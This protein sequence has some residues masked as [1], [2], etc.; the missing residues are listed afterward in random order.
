MKFKQWL[1]ARDSGTKWHDMKIVY[2]WDIESNWNKVLRRQKM[3]LWVSPNKDI[4][5][6]WATWMVSGNERDEGG[7]GKN[8]FYLHK[9]GMPRDLF[10]F[11]YN[12]ERKGWAPNAPR[13]L[14]IAPEHWNQ[15]EPISISSHQRSELL[16]RSFRAN[17]RREIHHNLPHGRL[18]PIKNPYAMTDER[19][20]KKA[21]PWTHKP[22]I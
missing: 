18:S 1:E 21:D 9:T 4:N 17:R 12:I 10:S 22:T 11:Y 8:T 15:L 5:D 13:E 14:V 19:F 2:H 7:E 3:G 16:K 20:F 6:S